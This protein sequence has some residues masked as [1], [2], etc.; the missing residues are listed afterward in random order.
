MEKTLKKIILFFAFRYGS[1]TNTYVSVRE[2]KAGFTQCTAEKF[3][4]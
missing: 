3:I 4:T 2:V 1:T